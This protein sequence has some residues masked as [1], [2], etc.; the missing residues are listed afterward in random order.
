[1]GLREDD[2]MQ[3]FEMRVDKISLVGSILYCTIF[4]LRANA[5]TVVGLV[6]P[7]RVGAGHEMG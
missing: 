4:V 7:A 1:M 5:S 6:T 2:Y 3:G